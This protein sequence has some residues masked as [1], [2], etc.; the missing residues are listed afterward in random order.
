MNALVGEVEISIVLVLNV[1]A[2]TD[3]VSVKRAPVTLTTV[4][5][6]AMA[7]SSPATIKRGRLPFGSEPST[8]VFALR[9]F[10]K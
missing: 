9:R 10:F 2:P 1:L 4:V 5:A 3:W 7:S 8:P 6:I